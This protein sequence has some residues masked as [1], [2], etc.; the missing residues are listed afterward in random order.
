MP[1]CAQLVKVALIPLIA[2]ATP[3]FAHHSFASFDMTKTETLLCTVKEF[4]WRNPHTW[5]VA[6][7]PD[8]AGN[9]KEFRFEGAPPAVLIR[10]GW[11]L[12]TLQVG[13]RI[14]LDYHPS[15][16]GGPGGTYIAVTLPNGKR[17]GASGAFFFGANSPEKP[18]NSPVP[19]DVSKPP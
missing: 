1:G 6:V 8:D 18:P 16:D 14:S 5:I 3:A 17:L 12:D 7:A 4:Q 13:D 11:T 15:R 19:S 9:P 2:M 10:S